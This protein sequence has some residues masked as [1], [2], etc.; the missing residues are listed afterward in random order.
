[1]E[2]R[3]K[4]IRGGECYY[5]TD[6]TYKEWKQK[7]LGHKDPRSTGTD[8]TYKEW[9]QGQRDIDRRVSLKHGSYLQGMETLEC[10]SVAFVHRSDGTDPTY[11]EW[12]HK[13]RR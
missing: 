7:L 3:L 8:P 12:K 13:T 1:M 6:P 4:T 2:T 5:G 11:K 10:A 9:K